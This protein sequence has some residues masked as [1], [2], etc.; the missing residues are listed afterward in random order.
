[1]TSD[2]LIQFS[3]FNVI[4]CFV[5]TYF[6]TFPWPSFC[7]S[8]WWTQLLVYFNLCRDSLI[9]EG[10]CCLC[11]LLL[12]FKCNHYWFFY[13][14]LHHRFNST[15]INQISVDW[16]LLYS[17][18]VYLCVVSSPL[19]ISLGCCVLWP[20]RVPQPQHKCQRSNAL[21]PP[22]SP[23][24][25]CYPSSSSSFSFHRFLLSPST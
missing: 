22:P 16:I 18:S 21:W 10:I 8:S 3:S 23:P 11:V 13:C 9:S 1:M 20:P 25:L 17:S 12:W 2:L 7:F 5:I 6:E 19:L 14:P 4:Y 24:S 15:Q